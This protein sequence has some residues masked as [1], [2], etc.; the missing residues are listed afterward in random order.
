MYTNKTSSILPIFPRY[1]YQDV[2]LRMKNL[3]PAK[4][5]GCDNISIKMNKIC[6][7][8]LP[9]RFK[10]N[11]RGVSKRRWN[12]RTLEESKYSSGTQKRR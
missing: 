7:G 2:S 4:G 8:S 10:N 1:H 11:V 6:F 5:N 3:N 12:S 9:V